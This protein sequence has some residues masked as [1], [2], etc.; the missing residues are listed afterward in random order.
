MGVERDYSNVPEESE[1][2]E[3]EDLDKDGVPDAV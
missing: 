2:E 3:M 1:D